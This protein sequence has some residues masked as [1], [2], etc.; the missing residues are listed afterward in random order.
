M[1]LWT[2]SVGGN[3]DKYPLWLPVLE[4]ILNT[5]SILQWIFTS[6]SE[7]WIAG[8]AS[9]RHKCRQRGL[10]CFTTIS[11]SNYQQKTHHYF[12]FPRLFVSDCKI[13]LHQNR[14]ARASISKG[15]EKMDVPAE[16]ESKNGQKWQKKIFYRS[17]EKRR[18]SIPILMQT[19]FT[20]SHKK[21]NECKHVVKKIQ[22]LQCKAS[23]RKIVL[24]GKTRKIVGFKR[25]F[26]Q[27]ES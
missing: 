1:L 6:A 4:T 14:N 10:Q 17:S 7:N 23:V 3:L 20:I 5:E 18:L 8:G 25:S 16:F 11:A 15:N 27:C 19:Y 22:I 26:L 24:A 2:L 9:R 12:T 21:W 13:G